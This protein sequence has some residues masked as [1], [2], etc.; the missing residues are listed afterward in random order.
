MKANQQPL[1]TAAFEK[2]VCRRARSILG[3]RG[4][5]VTALCL[6]SIRDHRGDHSEES[7]VKVAR[8]VADDSQY[9]AYPEH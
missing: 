2:E 1:S 3:M 7:I 8:S 5:K 9:W 6:N 4:S